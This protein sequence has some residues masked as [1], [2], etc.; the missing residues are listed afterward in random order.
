[1]SEAPDTW[2]PLK[3]FCSTVVWP[4]ESAVRAMIF[5]TE[6]YCMDCCIR[7]IGRRVLINPK[8][9]FE[10]IASGKS[11]KIKKQKKE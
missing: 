9:F 11:Y 10:L 1:M 3:L 5:N 6:E 7:R 4:S 8:L 2:M